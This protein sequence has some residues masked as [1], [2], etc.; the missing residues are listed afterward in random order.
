[1]KKII[2][3]IG[4]AK[5]GT[6]MIQTSLAKLASTTLKEHGYVYPNLSDADASAEGR[7]TSGNGTGLAK[8]L[9]DDLQVKAYS[10]RWNPKELFKKYKSSNLIL[11]SEYIMSYRV[12]KMLELLDIAKKFEYKVKIIVYM[13]S[14]CGHSL[15]SYA[16]HIKRAHYSETYEYFVENDYRNVF[17]PLMNKLQKISALSEIQVYNYDLE[18]SNLA[19]HFFSNVLNI[20]D[21]KFEKETINRSLSLYENEILREINK[22]TKGLPNGR[23]ITTVISDTLMTNQPNIKSMR[24]VSQKSIDILEK[25]Y[26]SHLYA[27]NSLLEDEN[28]ITIK[29]PTINIISEENFGLSEAEKSIVSVLSAII[30]LTNK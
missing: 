21:V 17:M 22:A 19:K 29:D 14:I 5:T 4:V 7:V 13:R 1:M 26:T 23:H 27:I 18:K 25:K 3:H 16:Q 15:S 24:E 30:M 2:L 8:W 20:D 11:S 10:T 6:S 9:N 28:K 12:D